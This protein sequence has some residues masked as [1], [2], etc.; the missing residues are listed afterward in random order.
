MNLSRH[1]H[2]VYGGIVF[3]LGFSTIDD[4]ADVTTLHARS[5]L[6]NLRLSESPSAIR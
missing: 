6:I 5:I 3:V 2:A 4:Q 1:I